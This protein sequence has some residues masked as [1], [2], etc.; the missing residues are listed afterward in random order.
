[1]PETRI[2]SLSAATLYDSPARA[3]KSSKECDPEFAAAAERAIDKLAELGATLEEIDLPD[4][5][6]LYVQARGVLKKE[7]VRY[8]RSPLRSKRT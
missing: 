2:A 6:S 8:L 1:M 5:R 4:Y 7:L 3:R